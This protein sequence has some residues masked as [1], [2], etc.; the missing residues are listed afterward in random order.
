MELPDRSTYYR[1]FQTHDA[2]FD[3]RVFVGVTST[4]I[5]CRPICPA[6]TPK[7]E[8]C[9]FF[10]SRRGARR[11]AFV[12]ACAAGR[13]RARPRLLARH[14]QHGEPRAGTDRRRRARRRGATSRRWPSGWASAGVSSAAC[15]SAI[16]APRRSPSPRRDACCSP[17]SCCTN[18]SADGRGGAG[19][20]LRQRAPLQ[21][22]LPATC[23]AAR[24]ARCAAK[25]AADDS[26]RARGVT[27]RLAYRPP[28]DW[29]GML[30]ALRRARDPGSGMGRR[31][32][33][34]IAASISTASRAASPSPICPRAIR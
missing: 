32:H 9:R 10:A 19:L 29:P 18:A 34:G 24:P 25:P 12:P 3:G 23:S 16:S 14:R 33:S 21:R 20:G 5:Y 27:L 2:R 15:S 6:R 8:N 26:T 4:G 1:A 11:R 30:A 17:S 28:Y 22:D 31:Q 7:L 13:D